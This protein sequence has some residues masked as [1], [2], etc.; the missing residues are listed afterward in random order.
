MK[1]AVLVLA[2]LA[3]GCT[4]RVLTATPEEISLTSAPAF[5]GDMGPIARDH[6][7]KHGK[8]AVMGGSNGATY[9][10]HCR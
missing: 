2:L 8:E 7:A 5:V 10:F 9:I 3:A 6:C 4:P 1:R